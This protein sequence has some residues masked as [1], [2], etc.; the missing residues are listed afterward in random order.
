MHAFGAHAVDGRRAERC[1]VQAHDAPQATRGENMNERN[2]L[3]DAGAYLLLILGL[4]F[5]LGP[6]YLAFCSATVS[7]SQLFSQGLAVIPGDQLLTNLAQVTQRLDLLRLL[8]NSLLVATLVVIG[9]LTLSALTAFAVVYFRSRY[10]SVI[11]FAVLGALL[12][13]LEVRIIPTY[14]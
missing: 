11:F 6:L 8:G 4:I 14:K 10:T 9:K 1:P 2:R 5:A 12:L 13:P 3:L 7:N